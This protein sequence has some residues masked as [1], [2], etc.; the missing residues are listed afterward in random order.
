MALL[1]PILASTA[2]DRASASVYDCSNRIDTRFLPLPHACRQLSGTDIASCNLFF[3]RSKDGAVRPCGDWRGDGNC[4]AGPRQLCDKPPSAEARR[5][6]MSEQVLGAIRRRRK[7]LKRASGAK[8]GEPCSSQSKG[9][10]RLADCER[11]CDD[12]DVDADI[13]RNQSER[14]S[15]S[16]LDRSS[17]PDGSSGS[18]SGSGSSHGSRAASEDEAVQ[19][20]K[21]LETRDARA[22][23]SA[24]KRRTPSTR[25]GMSRLAPCKYCKCRACKS[26]RNLKMPSW[27]LRTLAGV[28]A[29]CELFGTAACN[30][31]GNL[32]AT[33][34]RVEKEA[35]AR[36]LYNHSS[37][38]I[39][40]TFATT[41]RAEGEAYKA[42]APS[43]P[44]LVAAEDGLDASDVQRLRSAEEQSQTAAALSRYSGG[45]G[46]AAGSA[47]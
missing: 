22:R 35:Y 8:L 1:L 39:D 24:S 6:F 45:R 11:W 21:G 12:V 23:A 44:R 14:R 13:A 29:S 42:L 9:D 31:T 19:R 32:S 17:Q 37:Q 18:G 26:C 5:A 3:W 46:V 41:Y 30:A 28:R 38:W 34:R 36:W 7:L 25:G 20:R 16:R 2:F 4:E 47:G 15:G 33:I 40:A 43:L 27:A 10:V